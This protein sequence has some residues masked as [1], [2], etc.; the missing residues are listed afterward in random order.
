MTKLLQKL[1]VW[2]FGPEAI[3]SEVVAVEPMP[4]PQP[5]SVVHGGVVK[6]EPPIFTPYIQRHGGRMVK[7]MPRQLR[8]IKEAQERVE[9]ND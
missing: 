8:A 7:T 4:E 1:K 3:D 9:D 2:Y 6:T 5:E